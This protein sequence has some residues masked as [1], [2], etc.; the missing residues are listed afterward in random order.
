MN[1]D[2]QE[3]WGCMGI[4]GVRVILTLSGEL[5]NGA[6]VPIASE[7]VFEHIHCICCVVIIPV[8]SVIVEGFSAPSS[9][10][11]LDLQRL[12]VFFGEMLHESLSSLLRGG[13]MEDIVKFSRWKHDVR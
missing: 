9:G 13:R 4:W 8:I 1:V 12:D 3:R 5:L 7:R 2:E 6:I 10:S 11:G